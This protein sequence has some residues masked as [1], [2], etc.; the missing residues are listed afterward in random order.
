MTLTMSY[1]KEADHK[2]DQNKTDHCTSGFI[3][4]NRNSSRCIKIKSYVK[5]KPRP[6][7]SI[8]SSCLKR[9]RD[10]VIFFCKLSK[11]F[12]YLSVLIEPLASFKYGRFWSK[13][14]TAQVG[15]HIVLWRDAAAST[16][17]PSRDVANSETNMSAVSCGWCIYTRSSRLWTLRH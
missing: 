17:A 6:T 5:F 15:R 8:S 13:N 3:I 16:Q 1:E 7:C 9:S 2:S 11:M 14:F 4:K 10:W 12:A